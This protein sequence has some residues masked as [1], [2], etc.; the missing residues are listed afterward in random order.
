M[1]SEY[2]PL[3]SIVGGFSASQKCSAPCV[4]CYKKEN[5]DKYYLRDRMNVDFRILPDNIDCQA[6]IFNSKITSI[7]TKFLNVDSIRI[8]SIDESAKE[9]HQVIDTHKLGK[10]LSGENYTN[11]HLNRPV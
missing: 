2:C 7:E 1:T 10:K 11:G 6:R 8:D 4:A 9:L 3:G 5:P